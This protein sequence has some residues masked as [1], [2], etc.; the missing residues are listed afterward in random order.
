MVKHTRTIRRLLPRSC[1]SVFDHFVGLAIIGLFFFTNMKK[2][3]KNTLVL[4][5]LSPV[6]HFY[7][8]QKRQKTKGFM[9]FSGGIEMEH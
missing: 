8:P 6:F 4:T 3:G 1:L 2:K 7:T 5:H 9:T